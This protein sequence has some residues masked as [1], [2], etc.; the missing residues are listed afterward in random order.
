MLLEKIKTH[1]QQFGPYKPQSSDLTKVRE[2]N[3]RENKK[4]WNFQSQGPK[5]RLSHGQTLECKG[6]A[7]KVKKEKGGERVS[8][9]SRKEK[10][11]GQPSLTEGITRIRLTK[12][13]ERERNG[14]LR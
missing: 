4:H 1:E 14:V 6:D 8:A 13:G 2:E 3:G 11:G 10:K 12:A 7:S 9:K 5:D